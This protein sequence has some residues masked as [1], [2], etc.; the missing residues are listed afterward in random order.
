M[1]SFDKYRALIL[2]LSS[3]ISVTNKL[4]SANISAIDENFFYIHILPDDNLNVCEI[5]EYLLAYY[6]QN[7]DQWT[8]NDLCIVSNDENKFYRGQILDI[9]DN[10]YNVRCIDYGN[11]LQN[12]SHDHLFILSND[13]ILKQ[14]SLAHKCQLYGIDDINQRK[15]IDDIIQYIPITECLT[16]HIEKNDENN[17]CLVVTLIRED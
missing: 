3:L 12:I 8:I 4:L 14:S 9:N 15:A 5:E 10:K 1:L 2:S 16:I 17:Q 11:I 6:K 7:K 13:D